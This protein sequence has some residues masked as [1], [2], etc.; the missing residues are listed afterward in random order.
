MKK[1]S[2]KLMAILLVASMLFTNTSAVSA[3]GWWFSFLFENFD[4]KE[5][6]TTIEETTTIE[7]SLV[8]EDEESVEA[9][10]QAHPYDDK[11]EE[12]VEEAQKI[13]EE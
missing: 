1:F 2:K 3:K 10:S 11:D 12:T 5:E 8:V 13:E 4:K 6:E 7:E 9:G